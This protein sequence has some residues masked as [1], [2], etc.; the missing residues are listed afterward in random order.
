MHEAQDEDIYP[1]KI[2]RDERE[3]MTISDHD[4]NEERSPEPNHNLKFQLTAI[5][6]DELDKYAT[7]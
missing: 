2:D 7:V 3:E 6:E 1:T 5:V 4:D